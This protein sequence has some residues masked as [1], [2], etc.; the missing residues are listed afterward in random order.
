VEVIKEDKVTVLF[1]NVKTQA[2]IGNL[3]MVEEKKP[4]KKPANDKV[5][6]GAEKK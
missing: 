3:V 1:G 2:D 4:E 5:Q 6:S